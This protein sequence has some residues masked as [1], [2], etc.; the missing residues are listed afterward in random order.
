MKECEA[1]TC[2]LLILST[3]F[4]RA[5]AFSLLKRTD[6]C[7]VTQD[8]QIVVEGVPDLL[9]LKRR[10]RPGQVPSTEMRLAKGQVQKHAATLAQDPTVSIERGK[11]IPRRVRRFEYRAKRW[12]TAK[13]TGELRPLLWC[14]RL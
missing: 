3:V 5:R 7:S 4:S 12:A 14:S 13:R 11:P 8:I 2:E 10:S 6:L 1:C 9:N